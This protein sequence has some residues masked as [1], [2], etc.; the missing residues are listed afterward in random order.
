MPFHLAVLL[1]L[2]A[3]TLSAIFFY[4]RKIWKLRQAGKTWEQ[5]IE[6]W[7]DLVNDEFADELELEPEPAPS[8]NDY[9]WKG[10]LVDLLLWPISWLAYINNRVQKREM[11]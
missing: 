11:W 9:I 5:H 2:L 10:I 3:G 8:V 6:E 4:L 7:N 1:W